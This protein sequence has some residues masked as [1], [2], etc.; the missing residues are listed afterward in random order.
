MNPAII[1]AI[2]SLIE[3]LVR[4]VMT[5]RDAMRRNAEWTAEQ[6]AAFERHILRQLA[7]A[8]WRPD[9]EAAK[10]RIGEADSTL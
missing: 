2:G 8:H 6:E 9:A 3:T 10:N 4:S 5:A 7:Q 1:A